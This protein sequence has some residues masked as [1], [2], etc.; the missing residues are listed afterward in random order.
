MP[1][2]LRLLKQ[3]LGI[4]P[5]F[6]EIIQYAIEDMEDER[7]ITMVEAMFREKRKSNSSPSQRRNEHPPL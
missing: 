1:S 4:K 5:D 2:E 7:F 3:T 6:S